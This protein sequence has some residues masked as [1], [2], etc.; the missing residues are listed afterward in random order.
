MFD[1]VSWP[2]NPWSVLDELESLQS[3]MN[4]LFSGSDGRALRRNPYSGRS[5]SRATY[6]LLNV[7]ASEEGL[8]I[9][10]ELPGA[11][12]S[13]VDVSVTGDEL[14]IKGR[15]NGAN[16]DEQET[17]HRRERPAGEFTRVV[18]LPFRAD[19]GAVKAAYRNGLLRL[20][21]PRAK[22][23]KR[24]KIRIEA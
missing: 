11:D 17:Y 1:L 6:P 2:R 20:T 8:V 14:T 5:Y 22:E 24:K 13:D 3:D 23:D 18:Q 16:A 4:R 9:D 21:V 10:A 7:W 19:S 15:V 12:P